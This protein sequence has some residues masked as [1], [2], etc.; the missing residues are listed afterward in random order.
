MERR[1]IN[2][3]KRFAD[4]V[5][6]SVGQTQPPP[7]PNKSM[8]DALEAFGR[9]RLSKHY[10][11]RDFLYSE[12][13]AVHGI[14]NVPDDPEL[15]IEAGKGL[16]GHLLEPLREIFGHITI[17]SAFRSTTVNGYGN[18]HRLN[19]AR[20]ERNFA[21]HIWDY[22]DAD[23]YLG[24]TACIVVPWF[25]EYSGYVE[26]KAWWPLAWFI[27]DERNKRLPYSEME[28]YPRIAA[29]NLTWREKEPRHEIRAQTGCADARDGGG[30]S[31]RILTKPG[32]RNYEGDHSE[33]YQGF[34]GI[35]PAIFQRDG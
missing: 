4:E 20:N 7:A 18:K 22:R 23:G 25:L 29:F 6:I 2:N 26:R 33:H 34:P 3:L 31:P 28:F 13:A 19:C 5:R 9:E 15:A 8:M 10:F 16:C 17:R 32:C 11:M 30:C 35:Q 24:A 21:G 14:P 1:H 12:I 27:H